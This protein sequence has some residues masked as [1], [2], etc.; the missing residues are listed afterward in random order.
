MAILLYSADSRRVVVNY[1]RKYVHKALVNCSVRLAEEKSVVRWT[2]RSVM[3]IAVDWDIK[4]Q[5]NQPN[6]RTERDKCSKF[7]NIA[8]AFEGCNSYS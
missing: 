6:L 1:K 2:D 8:V 7:E 3:T 5:T 4:H